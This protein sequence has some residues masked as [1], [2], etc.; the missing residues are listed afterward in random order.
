MKIPAFVT[1]PSIYHGCSAWKAF[2]EENVTKVNM[3]NCGH[4]NVRKNRDIMNSEQYIA[5]EIS[6]KFGNMDNIK[7]TSSEPKDYLG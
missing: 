7:I 3:H 4:R 5:L 6:L 2:W 1:K